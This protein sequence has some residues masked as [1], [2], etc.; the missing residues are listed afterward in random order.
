MDENHQKDREELKNILRQLGRKNIWR[1]VVIPGT[2]LLADGIGDENDGIISHLHLLDFRNKTVIDLGCNL[3]YFCFIVKKAGAAR[4]LGIDKDPRIIHGCTLLKKLYQ[5]ENIDFQI[6]DITSLTADFASDVGMMIDF[7]G[8]Y[9]I[10]SGM[11]PRFLDALE[12][13]AKNEMILSVRPVY[14]V[15]KHLGNNRQELLRKYPEKYLRNGCFYTM[16]YILDR[17]GDNWRI[18]T[19]GAT[20]EKEDVIKELVV[21]LRKTP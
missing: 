2:Q 11:L 13:V 17:F 20:E 7:I 16:E 19:I 8:K 10:L 9:S 6:A 4:V 15:D 1:P 3:G 18:G 21:L 5:A 14:R 12:L